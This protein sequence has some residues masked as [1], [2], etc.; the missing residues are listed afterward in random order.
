MRSKSH[1]I[2]L[3]QH[4]C[5]GLAML[6]AACGG[7]SD[8]ETTAGPTQT[9]TAIKIGLLFPMSGP[10]VKGPAWR[11]AAEMAAAEI[12]AAGGVLG[13][14]IELI[15]ADTQTVPE[16]AVTAAQ[17]L[18]DEQVAAIVG[19]AASSST[20][21]AANNVTIPNKTLL[22]SPASTSP[23]IAALDDQNLVWR[24]VASD[25]FQGRLAAQW[26]YEEGA[27][28]AGVL[29][30]DNAYGE[31]LFAAFAAEFERL[32]G[33]VKNPV[34]YPE[35]SSDGIDGFS[36]ESRVDSVFSGSPDLIYLI[37]YDQDGAKITVTASSYITDSYRPIFL[38]CDGNQ[39][40]AFAD[41]ADPSIVEGMVGTL[42]VAP[43]ADG[44][45]RAFSERYR[46][47][48][49][50]KPESFSESTYDAIYLLALAAAQAES[51]DSQAM[52]AQLQ[53]IS[54]V[55]TLVSARD[56][57]AALALIAAGEDIDYVGAS[58]AV[59]FDANG[60]V[61]NGAYGIWRVENGEFVTLK[62]VAFP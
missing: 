49:G 30:V 1:F 34:N 6:I 18:V 7:N 44:N 50:V 19:A 56:Y 32:G 58:G 54:A 8:K 3:T 15:V 22:I 16:V 10:W 27:R 29:Y 41:N 26:A 25:Q 33:S 17:R 42:P 43:A 45:Y 52:A 37:T 21:L 24:T 28:T 9:E 38:G 23:A 48:Y 14:P 2:K 31:G 59:D 4:Y 5:I 53:A 13:R 61:L 47:L 36:Y 55:G 57:S 11:N 39:S 60:D 46:E 12:N 35:L 40:Q 62:T 20:I 51:V